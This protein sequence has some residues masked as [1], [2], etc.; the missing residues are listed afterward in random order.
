MSDAP[1]DG[2]ATIR[3]TPPCYTCAEGHMHLTSLRGRPFDYCGSVLLF[4]EDVM[5]PV[6]DTCGE[7]HLGGKRTNRVNAVLERLRLAVVARLADPDT[8]HPETDWGP[9]VG[10]EIW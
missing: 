4:D 9:P 3:A 1:I 6:C 10:R 7:V 5:V 2:S 8:H